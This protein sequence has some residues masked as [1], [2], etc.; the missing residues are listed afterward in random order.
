MNQADWDNHAN[1]LNP[2]HKEYWHCREQPEHNNRVQYS[3]DTS[4]D[5][6]YTSDDDQTCSRAPFVYA[7]KP[8]LHLVDPK[9][10]RWGVEYDENTFCGY[11]RDWP[12]DKPFVLPM[13]I[14]SLEMSARDGSILVDIESVQDLFDWNARTIQKWWQHVKR[15]RE[16]N[17]ADK[18]MASALQTLNNIRPN[19]ARISELEALLRS[20]RLETSQLEHK[21]ENEIRKVNKFALR[22][23]A[24]TRR[25]CYSPKL[26]SATGELNGVAFGEELIRR[27]SLR[28]L[29]YKYDQ[30][31]LFGDM[32]D[33]FLR[34]N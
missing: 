17:I 30:T 23:R 25:T 31:P 16:K 5:D 29:M 21:F 33:S 32:S 10:V 7:A 34:L 3:D 2:D 26:Y 28:R 11:R 20:L 18:Q 6:R 8:K 22:M 13:Y 19:R 12:R 4:D 24:Y 14:D 27:W 1:Q 9:T 15:Y